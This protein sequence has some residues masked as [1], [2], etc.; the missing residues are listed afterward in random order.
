MKIRSLISLA[1]AA[2]LITACS[3][4][5]DEELISTST[6]GILSATVEGNHSSTRAGFASDGKFYWSEK[7]QLGVTTSGNASKFTA[8]NLTNGNG[9]ASGTFDGIISGTIGDYA[10]YPYYD[11]H[12]INGATLTYNFPTSYTYNKVDA[13]YFTTVQG[14]GNSFNPAMWGKIVNG[15]VQMKHLGGVFCIKVPKMPIKAG[16]LSLIVDKKITGTFAVNLND[17]IPVIASTETSTSE[18]NTVTIEFSGATQDQPGVFYVPVPTGTY[19]VRIKVTESQGSTEKVNVAAG[20]YTIARCDLKKIELPNGN[21]DATVPTES[22]SLDDA[23]TALGNS[24]AVTVTGEVG[25]N[26]SISIPAASDGTAETAKSLSLEKVASGASLT[27]SDANSSGSTDNSVD[28]FTLSIPI[29]ETAEFKPLDV[30]I[31]MPNTTVA[32]TGNAGAAI[33][34]TVT[35]ETADNTLVIGNGVEV[36]KVIVKKG[37]IRVNKGAKLVAIEKSSDNQAT[38][39][40]VYK[41]DGAEIPS[42]WGE[43]FVVMDAAVAD[44]QK[45]FAEGG[46][47]TLPQDM[48]IV[49]VEMMVPKG[50]EVTLDLNG[51]TLE[52]ANNGF[53][54]VEGSFI[55]QDNAGNGV[56]KATKDYGSPYTTGIIY[57][58]GE[59]AKM[60]MKSGNIYAVRDNPANNGQFGIGLWR[61]ADLTIEGGKIETGWYAV[62]GNGLNTTQNS[63]I[64]ITGG[65][66]ISVVDYAVYLPQAGTTTISGGIIKGAC[67]AIGMRSGTLNINDQAKLIGEGTGDSGQWGDGTGTMGYAVINIGTGNQNTYGDC[68]VNITGGTFIAKGKSVGIAKRE[69]GAHHNITVSVTGGT[70]SDLSATD[71]IAE[72]GNVN[73]EFNKDIILTKQIITKGTM[74]LNLNGNT[75]SNTTNIWNEKT[76][77]WS[78]I[79]VQGKELT[80][81]GDGKLAALKDDCYALDVRNNATLTIEGGEYVG[82]VHTVYV[83]EGVANIKGGEY[84]IQQLAD[85]NKPYEFVLNCYDQHYKADPK[86]ANVIVTG[87]TFHKFNPA[88]NGAEGELDSTNFCP[89]GYTATTS[90]N[91]ETYV[92]SSTNNR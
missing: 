88:S 51:K 77:A 12:S 83:W 89:E 75:L 86:K 6:K 41:E 15:A 55:L 76:K 61:G 19:D 56:I 37:N 66:L 20:T 91:G 70:F 47:Y 52:A 48:N 82:N 54:R 23:A 80:I 65:E 31:T 38:T 42:S 22:N 1:M 43:E 69:D 81:K 32:L 18:N 9:T 34:G 84:S 92:V 39:V 46:T 40:T 30:T 78:L 72:D 60:T 33:Y 25:S 5:N 16:T 17:N 44:M 28:N 7:D 49:G 59:D 13:D 79:S 24:D 27:V 36:R 63:V 58:D 62:S 64:N 2:F 71:Y 45:V 90:D 21:I 68:T 8:L 85:G 57:V 29:N 53:I 73:I 74:T 87:G 10:V 35:S 11:N 4:E 3:N 26:S 67:G 50:K 14:E